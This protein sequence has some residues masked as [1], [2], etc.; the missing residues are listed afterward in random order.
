MSENQN[1]YEPP[2]ADANDSRRFSFRGEMLPACLS[3]LT[4]GSAF[5]LGSDWDPQ[6]EL[7]GVAICLGCVA[8][9]HA[10][11]IGDGAAPD[12]LLLVTGV[13]LTA[14][15]FTSWNRAKW[16]IAGAVTSVA[17]AIAAAAQG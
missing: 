2:S 13:S 10:R 8:W 17:A 12:I 3:L 11:L 6:I 16:P 7:I 15:V 1:P 14:Y 4:V 9:L 5:V